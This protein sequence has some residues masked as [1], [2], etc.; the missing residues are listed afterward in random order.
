MFRFCY[1]VFPDQDPTRIR[2]N[3]I[4]NKGQPK[5]FFQKKIRGSFQNET[6]KTHINV[7]NYKKVYEKVYAL[8][9]KQLNVKSLLETRVASL[10]EATPRWLQK[11][12]PPGSPADF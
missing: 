12:K 9:K 5:H 2:S 3:E 4:K 6:Y 10:F 8:P 11:V 7:C 1:F